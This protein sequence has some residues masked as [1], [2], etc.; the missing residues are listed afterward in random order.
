ML[1]SR[2][3]QPVNDPAL[4]AVR[5]L[6]HPGAD[7]VSLSRGAQEVMERALSE[8]GDLCRRLATGEEDLGVPR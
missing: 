3:G 5:L 2:I 8:V 1:V 6:P 4:T 7:F